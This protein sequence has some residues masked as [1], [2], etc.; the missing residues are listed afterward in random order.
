[1]KN[2]KIM[3]VC[4]F[5]LGTSMVLKLT[6]DQVLKNHQIEADTFC[7]DID[8]ALGQT[9]DIIVTSRTMVSHFTGRPEPIIVI[10][11]FL[12]TDEILEKVVPV[13]N[14]LNIT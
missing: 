7:S 3:I 14:K 13:I 2:L 9:F 4:C 10:G 1:M 8:T 5:G 6:M 12:S 11:D